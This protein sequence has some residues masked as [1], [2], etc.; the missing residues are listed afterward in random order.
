MIG[1]HVFDSQ[2]WRRAV[3]VGYRL[4]HVH[5]RALEFGK[6]GNAL[7]SCSKFV[8]S[9]TRRPSAL[10]VQIYTQSLLPCHSPCA[11]ATTYSELP[12]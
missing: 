9:S 1:K 2:P 4:P 11:T 7:M 6:F 8:N 10:P 12:Y 3:R 5:Q